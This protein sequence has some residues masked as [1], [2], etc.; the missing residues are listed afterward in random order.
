MHDDNLLIE[1]IQNGEAELFSVLYEK[2]CHKIVQFLFY[3]CNNMS[4]AQDLAGDSFLKAFDAIS[5]FRP[6][7]EKSFSSWLY[8]IATNTF[9]DSVK[10]KKESSLDEVGFM[11]ADEDAPNMMH[12]VQMSQQAEEILS[13]LEHLGDDKKELFVMRIWQ[14]L[15][16]EEI[17]EITWRSSAAL[18][19]EYSR[20]IQKLVEKFGY[21]AVLCLLCWPWIR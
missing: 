3:K 8:T 4:H 6:K 5:T 11:V 1:R 15:S 12:A 10:K 17:E 9:L 7:S 20:L 16:R 2:Y 19:K 13:H 18:R 14:E 21:M